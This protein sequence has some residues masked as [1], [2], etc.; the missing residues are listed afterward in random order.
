MG[1]IGRL[2][3]QKGHRYLV[4]AA[5]RRPVPASPRARVLIAGDGDL[6][7]EPARAG[8]RP[9]HRR[10]RRLRRAPH[11]RARPPRRPRRLLHL[12]A[13]RGHAARPLRGHG[14]GQGHRLDLGGRLPRGARGRRHRRARAPRRRGR[15][16]RRPR[17][18]PR[19]RRAPRALWAGRPSPPR[20]ATTCARASTRCRPSTTSSSAA[21]GAE[22]LPFRRL[23]RSAREAWE[24]P[25]DLLLR[26]YPP[27]VT[28]G[29]AAPR[30]TSPSSSSTAPS[31]CP[32]RESSLH[33]ADNGYVTLSADEYLAVLRGEREAPA[34]A[35]VL[36]F[37]DGRGSVWS[38]AAP[39]LRQHGMKAVV[40]LV[41][42]RVPSRPGP[43]A[44]DLGRRRGGPRPTR[45]VL[46]REEGEG[47][48]LSWE[49]IE[50]L[51][52]HRPL[53][54]PEPH[55]P[56]RPRPH[57]AAARRLR[58][59]PLPARLRRLRPAARSA[60]ATATSW[61]RRRRSARPSSAPPRAPRRRRGSSRTRRSARR[62]SPRSPR[63]AAR[64]SSC[65][66]TGR[67]ASGA[68]FGRTRV[69]GPAR[70][71]RRAGRRRSGA[72]S[73]T[74]R[75]LIEERTGPTRPSTSATR[76]TPRAPPPGGSPSR[77]ATRR[78][79]A[80]RCPAC[81]HAPRGRPAV[82]RPDR[83]GLRGAA[84]GPRAGDARRGPAPEVGAP[85]RGRAAVTCPPW[86]TRTRPRDRLP[87]AAGPPSRRRLPLPGASLALVVDKPGGA[88]RR[89]GWPCARA[90]SCWS[91]A[92]RE[93]HAGPR[94]LH[95]V[96]T[97]AD[98]AGRSRP[99]RPTS[100]ASSSTGSPARGSRRSSAST[101]SSR[102][103]CP[104][105]RATR[106]TSGARPSRRSPATSTPTR[107]SARSSTGQRR[108]AEADVVGEPRLP[109]PADH[110]LRAPEAPRGQRP[111][112]LPQ[113]QPW[114]RRAAAK[115]TDGMSSSA[116][117]LGSP[118]VIGGRRSPR[119]P[120]DSLVHQLD[121]HE[122]PERP[123]V[124]FGRPAVARAEPQRVEARAVV[125]EGR[126][127]R[128]EDDLPRLERRQDEAL[129]LA[130]EPH[131]HDVPRGPGGDD[132][133]DAGRGA[134]GPAARPPRFRRRG[135]RSPP[136]R[137]TTPA[138][139]CRRR[140]TT[141]SRTAGP[142]PAGAPGRRRARCRAGACARRRRTPTGRRAS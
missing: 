122:R 41:P 45:P 113:D 25:R 142:R 137:R 82:D 49:E 68:L 120:V 80:A 130:A 27:F 12:V 98:R 31:L 104:S 16:R 128:I 13:L 78:P 39:L 48:L 42:G 85:L 124:R 33:L 116:D 28:G 63:T 2:N 93:A 110:R 9:R 7:G 65:A 126:A 118:G 38:V 4:D 11:R 59:P 139:R 112:A 88:L 20:A 136:C 106:A 22:P 29:D 43:L 102:K 73:P 92:D 5:A 57:R 34:R 111:R 18:R 70:D 79:S 58:D 55:P 107:T 99:C 97:V 140:G 129:P 131:R 135:A 23:G 117:D 132:E 138:R 6:M 51:A 95:A 100:T 127:R 133:A 15:P 75:R 32:S 64:A 44:A 54:L 21:G 123:L 84:P 3:A 30:A 72:S 89:C 37:D 121:L 46:R 17:A 52:R 114:P 101:C 1:T 103:R 26:R 71:G 69:R 40:F 115:R 91:S 66:P 8:R 62:A 119:P 83:R 53:R 77:P 50:A 105:R 74:A 19:R 35:V 47:A 60:R 108:S 81:P 56:P 96:G 24:V 86:T 90:A 141:G 134:R 109:A 10:P 67:T 125:A 87:T 76:G 94:D 61:A 14:G 36:T